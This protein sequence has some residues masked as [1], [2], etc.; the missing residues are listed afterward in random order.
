MR[1]DGQQDLPRVAARAGAVALA[2][3]AARVGVR[4]R[5][6]RPGQ[7]ARR[8]RSY[9]PGRSACRVVSHRG[10]EPDDVAVRVDV[11]TFV[12]SPVSVLGKADRSAC[13]LPRPGEFVGVLDEEI[14]GCVPIG[15]MH[16]SEMNLGA[17]KDGKAVP[18]TFVL[19]RGK[20][21]PPVMLKRDAEVTDW[22][23]RCHLLRIAHQASL[24]RLRVRQRAQVEP[25]GSAPGGG[26]TCAIGTLSRRGG[27]L[28]HW[29]RHEHR[30]AAR[31]VPRSTMGCGCRPMACRPG[32]GHDCCRADA[33]LHVTH[34]RSVRVTDGPAL[35]KGAPA[36]IHQHWEDDE[37]K[38]CTGASAYWL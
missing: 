4:R 31:R 10:A 7:A 11:R 16:K 9:L 5:S 24:S 21:E 8:R 29:T 33:S 2:G 1:I 26:A 36:M 28:G 25:A 14:C 6:R 37:V 13:G 20:A 38:E 17:I 22:E 19:A 27:W 23:Y 30:N 18:A 34:A 35:V 15:L 12:L 3:Q 32:A